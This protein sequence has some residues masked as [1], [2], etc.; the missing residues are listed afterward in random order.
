MIQKKP[1][2]SNFNWNSSFKPNW[3]PR[4][5]PCE[6]VHSAYHGHEQKLREG[7]PWRKLNE[8][9]N[10][11][12]Q[13]SCPIGLYLHLPHESRVQHNFR[14]SISAFSSGIAVHKYSPR[15]TVDKKQLLKFWFLLLV[16]GIAVTILVYGYTR[17]KSRNWHSKVAFSLPLDGHFNRSS[18]CG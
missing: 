16:Y 4:R 13:S 14:M 8:W 15:Y 12:K 5:R 18:G 7:K 11:Q 9:M 1:N 10:D 6:P 2:I 17:T 3:V